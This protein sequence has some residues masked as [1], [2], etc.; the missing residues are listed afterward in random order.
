MSCP[1]APQAQEV[2][3]KVRGMGAGGGAQVRNE[4]QF[5]LNATA[6]KHFCC[7]GKVLKTQS[8]QGFL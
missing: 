3:L 4:I 5:P 8:L 6:N 7:S 2:S 1:F